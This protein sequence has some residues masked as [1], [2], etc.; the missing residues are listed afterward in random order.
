MNNSK[1]GGKLDKIK[2]LKSRIFFTIGILVIYRIGTYLPLPGIDPLIFK[3]ISSQNQSGILGMLNMFS[4][5]ALGRMTIFSLNVIPYITASIIMQLLTTTTPSLN[6]LKKSGE[7]GRKK[8]AQY[9]KYF[10]ILLALFQSY[11]IAVGLENLSADAGAAVLYQGGFFRLTTVVS[12]VG[13]T[14]FLLWLGD[15]I[16]SRGIGNGISLIIFAGIVAELP[17]ALI[18]TIELGRTGIYS[19]FFILFIILLVIS[20]ISV[21]VFFERSFRNVTVQYPKRNMGNRMSN[22][23]GSQLPLKLNTSGVIPPIFASSLLLF[24]ITI[25][26]FG[27][28]TNPTA[29]SS[30]VSSNLAHGKPLFIIIYSVLIAF[31]CFF[32]TAI[33]FNAKETADQLKKAGGFI[34]GVRP[35][36][37]T[38]TYLDDVLSRITVIG[39]I[40]LVVICIIP[41]LVIAKYSL[42]FY[43]G[44][45]SLLIVVNVAMD[46]LTQVQSHLLS[47]KYDSVV[48]KNRIKIRA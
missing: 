31:F 6:E 42:P 12:L 3:Q 44:G 15:Q 40:Y 36:E 19:T 4:G 34:A 20:L 35:G 10:T 23:E 9:T 5:G 47:N 18:S 22:V 46:S 33:V 39:A 37:Q 41:E 38:A 17:S 2:D 25:I 8:I 24:P 11:G 7:E 16:T 45:T 48:R 28:T 27:N 14:M 21:I 43:L 1:V 29:F 26:S 13:S 30:F 32:Y